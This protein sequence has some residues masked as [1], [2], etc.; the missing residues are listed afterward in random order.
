MLAIACPT[1]IRFCGHPM[2]TSPLYKPC[3]Q[4]R[5]LTPHSVATWVTVRLSAITARTAF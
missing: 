1:R 3:M 5:L 2:I 4:C